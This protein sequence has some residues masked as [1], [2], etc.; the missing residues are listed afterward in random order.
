MSQLLHAA[1]SAHNSGALDLAAE[2]YE[3]FLIIE[4]DHFKA[5]NLSGVLMGQ[6]DKPARGVELLERALTV[7]PDNGDANANMGLMLSKLGRHAQ[8]IGFLTKAIKKHPENPGYL[9]NLAFVLVSFEKPEDAI[10][11][12]DIL[13]G[14]DPQDARAYHARGN[15]LLLKSEAKAALENY[16]IALAAHANDPR[17]WSNVGVAH[18]WLKNDAEAMG[19]HEMALA[20]DPTSIDA[21]WERALTL[22]TFGK[23]EEGWRDYVSAKAERG[24]PS[25]PQVGQVWDG[26]ADLRNKSIFIYREQGLG[27]SIQFCRFVKHLSDT[28]AKVFFAPHGPLKWIMRSMAGEFEVCDFADPHL[29][30]DYHAPLLSLPAYFTAHAPS[31][32]APYLFPSDQNVLK[33][34]AGLGSEGFKIGVCWQGS[35]GKADF[36]RSIPLAHFH[37]LS[38]I[39]GVRLISLHKGDGERQLGA[40]PPQMN[41]ETLG[42][43]FDSGPD[44]FYDTAAVMKSLDLVVTSDTAVAH[45]AGALGAPVWVALKSAPDWRWMMDRTD[46]PWYP[47]MRLFRQQTA[48]DWERVFADMQAALQDLLLMSAN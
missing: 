18:R 10:G 19:S 34:R 41:I 22:L 33:W 7:D 27:D 4:P 36:G 35:T 26:K 9:Q 44:G 20:L 37:A 15:A 16:E 14:L 25:R 31:S 45:L 1:M 48:G 46:S 11:V 47:T 6:L 24:L 8:A 32:Q 12:A 39:P 43:D 38:N 30:T 2:L 29:E 23:F 17:L 3:A 42:S 40:L 28:G 5:L 21:R 13:L